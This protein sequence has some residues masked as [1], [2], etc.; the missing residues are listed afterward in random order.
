MDLGDA[1][2]LAGA[3]LDGFEDALDAGG[4]DELE[5]SP[6]GRAGL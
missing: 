3:P 2:L 5:R 4:M 6:Q 1:P